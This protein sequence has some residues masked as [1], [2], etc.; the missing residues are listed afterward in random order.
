MKRSYTLAAGLCALLVIGGTLAA[1]AQEPIPLDQ[2]IKDG[3]VKAEISGTGG[4]TGDSILLKVQ[5]QTPDTLVLTMAAGTVFK[6]VGGNAQNMAG[7]AIK[8]ERVGDKK[9]R[10]SATIVLEDSA[11]HTYII[12][13]YCLDFHKANPSTTDSFTIA[14]ADAMAQRIIAAG[15]QSGGGIKVIQSALW[16][17]RDKLT[18]RELKSRFPVT[19]EEVAAARALLKQIQ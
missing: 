16:I 4:S 14:P 13:A 10:R 8:G 3:K 7:A 17:Y 18:D 9:Y 5:R 6:N 11:R 1:S 19:D 12:E 2:A 15:K